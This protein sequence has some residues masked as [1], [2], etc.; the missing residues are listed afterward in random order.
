MQDKSKFRMIA[1]TLSYSIRSGE[2]VSGDKFYTRKELQERFQISSMTA[3]HVQRI[4]H[5]SGLIAKVPGMG[6]VVNYPELLQGGR[7]DAALTK[8]RMIGSPQAIGEEALFGS[9][10]VAGAREMCEKH[11][12]Q[13]NLELVQVLDNPA[14]IINT[15]RRLDPDEA[16]LLFLHDELLPEV[17]NLLLAP[18]V[19]AVTVNRTF[20]GKAA[21]L[22]NWH[23][24]A[25]KMLDFCY[26]KG[27]KKL[28]YAG[29]CAFWNVPMHES[30]LFRNI[31][32]QTVDFQWETDFSG[33]FIQLTE[34]LRD[35]RPDAVIF[36]HADAAVHLMNKYLPGS[37]EKRPLML[38]YGYP[39]KQND[40]SRLD[41]VY[42]S[43]GLEMGR[44]A[45]ELLLQPDMASRTPLF[46]YVNGNLKEPTCL[47]HI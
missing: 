11:G 12:L 47:E 31:Q 35:F 7:R 24:M 32:S 37:E 41:A 22:P 43:D 2:L 28:L 29:N 17:V 18:T 26:R 20:P 4:L 6:F 13:F 39:V 33:N 30:E 9:Q 5:E 8:I 23:T 1:D 16:L 3:F 44:Q 14:H 27:V 25:K 21:V 46:R 40:W 45:V 19:R 34:H 10:I 36:S 15:S 38:G 42:L